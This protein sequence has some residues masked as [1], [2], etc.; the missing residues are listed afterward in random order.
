[1][2]RQDGILLMECIQPGFFEREYI[3][4]LPAELI[5]DEMVVKLSE[6]DDSQYEKKFDDNITFGYYEGDL[7][8]LKEAVGKVLE[9]WLGYYDG[10]NRVFC[11]F[12]DGKIASFCLIENMG[13]H[14][15]N[16]KVLKIGGPGCVGTVPEY[17]NKGIG[18]TMVNQVTQILK[19]EG[20]DYSYIHFTGVADWYS[21]IGYKTTVKWNRDGVL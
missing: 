3:K 12:I 21:K 2:D 19:N 1:M 17:R 18:L 4:N 16:G 10:N 14:N 6:F 5:C 8:E 7:D 13:T 11:G 9:A 20:Y 15:I